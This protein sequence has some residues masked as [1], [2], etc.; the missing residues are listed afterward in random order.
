MRTICPTLFARARRTARA[1]ALASTGTMPPGS[2]ARLT[3]RGP[4]ADPGTRAAYRGNLVDGCQRAIRGMR[5]RCEDRSGFILTSLVSLRF[6]S[7][8]G[9]A[10]CK[11]AFGCAF[12]RALF[13][14]PLLQ[15]GPFDGCHHLSVP[16]QALVLPL[17]WTRVFA[18]K[19][20]PS[21]ARCTCCRHRRRHC[22]RRSGLVRWVKAGAVTGGRRP[23]RWLGGRVGGWISAWRQRERGPVLQA[24]LPACLHHSPPFSPLLLLPL[25]PVLTRPPPT[26]SPCSLRIAASTSWWT[27][28]RAP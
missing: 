18:P 21:A 11:S 13:R 6:G 14:L 26:S 2:S 22:L 27:R 25:P 23:S 20:G 15:L 17:R 1:R 9:W 5:G 19:G 8:L 28:L 24:C 16:L 7:R 3:R 10:P 4:K 12:A